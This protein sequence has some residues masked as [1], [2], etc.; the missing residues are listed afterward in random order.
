MEDEDEVLA[1]WGA[2]QQQQ[3]GRITHRCTCAHPTAHLILSGLPSFPIAYTNQSKSIQL[4][5]GRV[6]DPANS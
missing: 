3:L 2:E 5:R 6:A 1:G 4:L